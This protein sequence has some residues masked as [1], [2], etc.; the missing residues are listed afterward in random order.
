MRQPFDIS[1]KQLNRSPFDNPRL[2]SGPFWGELRIFLAVAKAKSFNRAAEELNIS[3]PTVSRQVRRLQDMI[4]SQLVVSTQNGI[5]LTKKGQELAATLLTLDEQLFEISHEL[6]AEKQD[7]EGLVRVSVTEALAGLFVVPNLLPFGEMFP[8]LH[9]HIRNPINLTDFRENQTDV[10]I[11]FIPCHQSGVTMKTLGYLHFL[12]MASHSY[13]E[14]VGMPTHKNLH[15][16]YFLDTEYYSAKTT[17]WTQWRSQ[18]SQGTLAHYCDNSFAYGL[19]A[20]AGMGIAL[21]GNYALAE[22]DLVPL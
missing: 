9:L 19:M 6:K 14:R 8:K 20:K 12:P 2:L 21:L 22:P 13:I 17:A 10:M 18:V 11:G 1:Q 16:H 3:Q 7:A 5:R 15:K 4:G